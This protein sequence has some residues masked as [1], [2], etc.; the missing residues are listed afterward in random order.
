MTVQT[1]D[2][3]LVSPDDSLVA[4]YRD[5]FSLTELEHR[6]FPMGTVRRLQC[7]PGVLK[8]M[9]PTDAPVSPTAVDPFWSAAGIRYLTLYVDDL[10][11]VAQRCIANGGRVVTPAFELRPGV[12]TAVLHDP[13]GNTVEVMQLG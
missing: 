1:F 9:I 12:S 5:T 6:E 4:F 13:Q 11:E 3:G 10:G 2:I 7:G 8:V